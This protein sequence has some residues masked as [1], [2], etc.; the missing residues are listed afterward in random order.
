MTLADLGWNETFEAEFAP[1]LE[2]G[3]KPARLIRDNKY[4]I[5]A[6]LEYGYG[7]FRFPLEELKTMLQYC[8]DALA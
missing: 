7:S 8:K 2:R 3:W 5:R 6:Y 4:P 1:Y